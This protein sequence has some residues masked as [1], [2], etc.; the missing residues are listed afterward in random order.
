MNLT[1]ILRR[2]WLRAGGVAADAAYAQRLVMTR[3]LAMDSYSPNP[4]ALPGTYQEFLARTSHPLWR[5]PSARRR[6]AGASV[7]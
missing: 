5:E 7:R 2:L 1:P 4:D 6:L 3:R